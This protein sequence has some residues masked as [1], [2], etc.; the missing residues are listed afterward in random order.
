MEFPKASFTVPFTVAVYVVSVLRKALGWKL[1]VVVVESNVTVP[2][3]T[4]FDESL[5]TTF[6]DVM[7][8][9]FIGS[10]N[11][12]EMVGI[13][14]VPDVPFAGVSERTVGGVVGLVGM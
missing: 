7:V 9:A 3:T 13:K 14:L 10:L 2:A 5:T 4:L 12:A 8:V 11:C 1:R 6:D